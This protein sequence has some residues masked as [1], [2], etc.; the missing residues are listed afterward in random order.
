MLNKPLS[1]VE[2][3]IKQITLSSEVTLKLSRLQFRFIAFCMSSMIILNSL[4]WEKMHRLSFGIFKSK[5]L[6]FMLHHSL[7]P[8]EELWTNSILFLVKISGL[9]GTLV[10]DDTDRLRAKETSELYGVSKVKDKKTSGYSMA[11]NI[12]F[13]VFVTKYLTIPVGF[14]FFR[15]DPNW[16]KWKEEDEKLRKNGVKKSERPKKPPRDPNYPSRIAIT[17]SLMSKFQKLVPDASI[18]AITAD[19]AFLTT[20]LIRGVEKLF[21]NTQL[22]S[23][24]R[25]NALV[26]DGQN[27]K[28]KKGLN[29]EKYFANKAFTE[30][31]I[32]LRGMSP[33]KVKLISARLYVHSQKR[34]FHIV[35]LKYDEETE[36]RYLVAIKLSWRAVDLVRQYSLRWL[37]EVV[38]EDWKVYDGWGRMAFQRG[39]DGARRGVFLS[40]LVDHFLCSHPFQLKQLSTNKPLWTSGSLSR[41]FQS[42]AILQGIEAIIKD[43]EPD[44]RL[45]E[46]KDSIQNIVDFRASDKHM[47]GH[48]IGEFEESLSLKLRYKNVS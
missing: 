37:V 15:P 25:K 9:K 2:D 35:A 11:Q 33:K 23:Q 39:A 48:N 10:V 44:K 3:F 29:V 20:E 24:I 31:E 12:V 16:K 13:L 42:S 34:K 32:P 4:C 1:D 17:I 27:A 28:D 14:S 30:V 26:S 19:A 38:I 40:L 18:T 47:S 7:I 43:S 22:I 21:P 8:W 5:A 46:L 6:S 45:K 41:F 36:Y